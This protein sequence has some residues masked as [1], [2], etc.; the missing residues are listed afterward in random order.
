[1]ATDW[2][3]TFRNWAKPPSDTEQE[4]CDN[5]ERMIRGALKASSPL[6]KRNIAVFT[7]GSYRNNTNVRLNSDVDI[8]V[9]CK[10]VLFDDYSMS[11]GLS[12]QETGI[13]PSDYS[14]AQFKVEVGTALTTLFGTTN[15]SR[16]NKAFEVHANTY[17]VDADVVPAFEHRRY[18]R[19]PAGGF[20]YLSGTEL[21]PDNGGSI[22]N[23]PNQHAENGVAKNKATGG[24]F[25]AIVRVLKRARDAMVE[26][27]IPA[28]QPAASFL[29]ESLIWNVPNEAFGHT[30]YRAD[31]RYS[32]AHLFNNTLRAETCN[33]WGEVSELKYLFRGSQPWTR[34][35]ANGFLSAAWDYLGFD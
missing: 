12:R 21:R 24:R 8:C 33:E 25:K 35:D 27:G 20:Y 14:Y 13:V 7:Q 26:G 11:G 1:M 29:V 10:D 31:L 5:A 18:L 34:A 3:Q 4:K 9:L 30:E 17:R 6:A 28:A 2:E 16:G 19:N 23:W 15:V 32:L 22:V